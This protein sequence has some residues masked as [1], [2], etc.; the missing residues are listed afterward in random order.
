MTKPTTATKTQGE[1]NMA[2]IPNF[3][4]LLGSVNEAVEVGKKIMEPWKNASQY[5]KSQP[6]LVMK[7]KNGSAA[8][9][10]VVFSLS[11]GSISR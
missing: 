10:R 9:S 8:K 5:R 4:E 2:E 7:L 11:N 3:A 1:R 6:Y